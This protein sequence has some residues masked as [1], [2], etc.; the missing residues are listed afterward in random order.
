MFYVNLAPSEEGGP[1][2]EEEERGLNYYLHPDIKIELLFAQQ[3]KH[4]HI[5]QLLKLSQRQLKDFSVPV[6]RL[7]TDSTEVPN[8]QPVFTKLRE[9]SSWIKPVEISPEPMKILEQTTEAVVDDASLQVLEDA[10][11]DESS[12][13]IMD[14]KDAVIESETMTE[15]PD[16]T[17][18]KEDI[19]WNA[20]TVKNVTKDFEQ[21]IQVSVPKS[22]KRSRSASTSSTSSSSLGSGDEAANESNN[23]KTEFQEAVMDT[24]LHKD[25]KGLP[26]SDEV[27]ET[28][29]QQLEKQHEAAAAAARPTSIYDTE[30]IPLEPGIVRRTKQEIESRKIVDVPAEPSVQFTINQKDDRNTKKDRKSD[31]LSTGMPTL[32]E[33]AVKVEV[34]K[35]AQSKPSKL[36]EETEMHVVGVATGSAASGSTKTSSCTTASAVTDST[37]GLA[38]TGS[39]T[40]GSV[41]AGSATNSSAA[42]G[43]GTIG[44]PTSHK[45]D[46]QR[47]VCKIGQEAVEMPVGIV[48]K[49]HREFANW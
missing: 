44:S 18:K 25:T 11:V 34:G 45:E 23:A 43:S 49:L 8:P 15:D 30:E 35:E 31:R 3:R 32:Q 36:K 14:D 24:T 33:S 5:A 19:P 7:D 9:D 29:A 1:P 40:T 22:R 4:R 16:K 17:Y 10:T 12:T 48:D 47:R 28:D 38:A 41:A 6:V 26:S 21:R 2:E 37:A 46:T 20:G 13:D 42:I 27:S 39:A